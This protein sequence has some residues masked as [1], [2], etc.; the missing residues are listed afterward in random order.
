M[1]LVFTEASEDTVFALWC[2]NDVHHGKNEKDSPAGCQGAVEEILWCVIHATLEGHQ[3]T[4]QAEQCLSF[5]KCHQGWNSVVSWVQIRFLMPQRW[6]GQP[7]KNRFQKLIFSW[8]WLPVEA[9]VDTVL[10]LLLWPLCSQLCLESIVLDPEVTEMI[11]ISFSS[12]SKAL[13]LVASLSHTHFQ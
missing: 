2:S 10:I 3:S 6:N 11:F 4:E 12:S 5:L 7:S 8:V 13:L 9:Q 1:W